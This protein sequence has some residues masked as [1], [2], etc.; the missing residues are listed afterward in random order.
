MTE[1][2]KGALSGDP[3][4]TTSVPPGRIRVASR[5]LLLQLDAGA[6]LFQ[7]CTGEPMVPP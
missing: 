4:Y 2:A 5:T 6:G 7:L 1:G 3:D